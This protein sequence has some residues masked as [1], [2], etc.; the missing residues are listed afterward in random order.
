MYCKLQ[1]KPKASGSSPSCQH[2]LSFAD[3]RFI[4]KQMLALENKIVWQHNREQDSGCRVSFSPTNSKNL[5]E[6]RAD[7]LQGAQW[8]IKQQ[9]TMGKGSVIYRENNFNKKI[10]GLC[11]RWIRNKL[12]PVTVCIQSPLEEQTG[13]N[14]QEV[15]NIRGKT[16]VF[17]WWREV[18]FDSSYQAF[19]K[20]QEFKKFVYGGN[21]Q[22]RSERIQNNKSNKIINCIMITLWEEL[23]S[24]ACVSSETHNLQHVFVFLL[25]FYTQIGGH[26]ARRS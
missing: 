25:V 1:T 17:D 19:Q 13:L 22:S 24:L 20:I 9:Q 15:W 5:K 18:R 10:Y 12:R 11:L 7:R 16:T 23:I 26:F 2:S 14:Y 4:N 6:E 21:V 3:H 8:T